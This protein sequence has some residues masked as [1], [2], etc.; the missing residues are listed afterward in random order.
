MSNTLD[1]YPAGFAAGE[2]DRTLPGQGRSRGTV[3]SVDG[4]AQFSFQPSLFNISVNRSWDSFITY[5]ASAGASSVWA[6]DFGQRGEVLRPVPSNAT[7]LS[8]TNGTLT[9]RINKQGQCSALLSP[10]LA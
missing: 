7:S 5:N 2:L 1:L 9:Y 6:H 3:F 10:P 8:S 4:T